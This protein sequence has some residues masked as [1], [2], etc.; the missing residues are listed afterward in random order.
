ML[1]STG[2]ARFATW[3]LPL[4]LCAVSPAVAA[5]PQEPEL[6]PDHAAKMKRGLVTFESHVRPLLVQE[7]LRCHGGEET[8][9]EFNL[10]TREGLLKA[11]IPRP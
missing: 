5:D 2:A 8:E 11:G 9:S 3:I 10:S 7:C 1:R 4:I 6:D